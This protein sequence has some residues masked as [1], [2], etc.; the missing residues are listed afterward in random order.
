MS[1]FLTIVRE[2][3]GQ[4]SQASRHII[5]Y[6]LIYS[7]TASLCAETTMDHASRLKRF[8]LFH[9]T[10]GTLWCELEGCMGDVSCYLFQLSKSRYLQAG[11]LPLL[12]VYPS[13]L[14]GVQGHNKPCVPLLKG[15]F[16]KQLTNGQFSTTQDINKK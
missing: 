4:F 5:T 8:Q 11:S 2:A 15:Y 16:H 6:S 12:A 3:T 14:Q 7:P 13:A 1:L 10:V 9:N